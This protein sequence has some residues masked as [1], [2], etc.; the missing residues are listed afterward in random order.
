MD[1]KKQKQ[2]VGAK[3]KKLREKNDLTQ[4]EL[5]KA[6][7]KSSAAYIA[8][9][10]NGDRNVSMVDLMKIAKVLHTSVSYLMLEE[11]E[12]D[13]SPANV[14]FRGGATAFDEEQ[15]ER[16]EQEFKF[17]RG[18]ERSFDNLAEPRK[19]LVEAEAEKTWREM[20]GAKVP[21]FLNDIVSALGV[22]VKPTTEI[23]DVEGFAMSKR[24]GVYIMYNKNHP[25]NRQRFT[26]AHELGH[27]ILHIKGTEN[28]ESQPSQNSQEIEANLFANALLVPREHLK[29]FVKDR[30][31]TLSDI[32]EK[33]EVSREVASIAVMSQRGLLNKL[34]PEETSIDF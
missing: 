11:D 14:K 12:E 29:K 22:P 26:V 5:A 23:V 18:V 24:S 34:K 15:E 32:C 17:G 21:V 2:L 7:G 3:I 33:Y 20:C 25:R 13:L 19:K 10:E 6:S 31:K 27:V 1:D 28:R 16:V 9:I 4:E 8:L 30:D